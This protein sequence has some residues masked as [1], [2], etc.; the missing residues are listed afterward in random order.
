MLCKKYKDAQR[1]VDQ[2]ENSGD[3][4]D[5]AKINGYTDFTVVLAKLK[6]VSKYVEAIRVERTGRQNASRY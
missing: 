5:D 6:W 2:I 1:K 4:P 3:L